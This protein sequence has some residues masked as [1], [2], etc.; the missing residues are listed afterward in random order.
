MFNKKIMEII[1]NPKKDKWV[2]I[3][4]RPEIESAD[5]E[6]MCKEIFWQVQLL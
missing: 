5:L 6:N 1:I 2:E 4:K 3:C